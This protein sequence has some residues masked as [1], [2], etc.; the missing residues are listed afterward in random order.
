MQVPCTDPFVQVPYGR[1]YTLTY[2]VIEMGT[3]ICVEYANKVLPSNQIYA[4]LYNTV[5]SGPMGTASVPLQFAI[6]CGY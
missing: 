4:Y 3:Y 5:Q 1:D 2:I 6:C